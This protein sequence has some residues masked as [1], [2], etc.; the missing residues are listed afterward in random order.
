MH[1]SSAAAA[2]ANQLPLS[3]YG[4]EMYSLSESRKAVRKKSQARY[5]H[6]NLTLPLFNLNGEVAIL[7]DHEET[8]TNSEIKAVALSYMDGMATVVE[9]TSVL[10]SEDEAIR[11]HSC[12]LEQSIKALAAGGNA[13][14]KKEILDWLF[15]PDILGIDENNN[16]VYAEQ[17]P[18]TYQLCCKLEGMN[19]DVIL[20]F[21]GAR[22]RVCA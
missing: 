17:R 19:P 20:D 22:L 10:W 9:E 13:G 8:E 16:F 6:I 2:K 11:L 5:D 15:A 3:L 4:G 1:L 12:L 14:Q 18:F 7:F 21:I